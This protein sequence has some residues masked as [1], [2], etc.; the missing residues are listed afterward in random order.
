MQR[1]LY[2]YVFIVK[3][4]AI[5]NNPEYGTDEILQV[6]SDASVS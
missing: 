6:N 2:A 4:G 3:S 1:S 5:V